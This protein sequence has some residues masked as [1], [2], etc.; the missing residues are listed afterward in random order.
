MQKEYPSKTRIIINN[1]KTIFITTN[2]YVSHQP[3][4]IQM[5]KFKWL[6]GGD[7]AL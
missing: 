5:E 2:A 1:D 6:D 7:D 3:K 4:E